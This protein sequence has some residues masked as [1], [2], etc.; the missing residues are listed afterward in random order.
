MAAQPGPQDTYYTLQYALM[1]TLSMYEATGDTQY[2]EL[3]LTWA[4]TMISKAVVIDHSG[5]RNWPGPWDSPY[6]KEPI[7]Y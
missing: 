2:L 4:E 7:Y 5:K 6:A 1:G 3:V